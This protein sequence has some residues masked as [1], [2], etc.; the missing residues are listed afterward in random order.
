VTWNTT[1]LNT[2]NFWTVQVVIED[3]DANGNVKTKTPVDFLLKISTLVGNAPTCSITP[4]TDP[5][6]VAVGPVS[7]TVTGD[8]VDAGSTIEINVGGLPPGATMTP[9]LPTSGAPPISSV[10]NWVPGPGDAGTSH[11]VFFTVTDNNARQSQCSRRIIITSDWRL[12]VELSD[13][14]LTSNTDRVNLMWQTASEVDN[15][16]F[17]VYRSEENNADNFRLIASY[18]SDASLKGLGT[19]STGKRYTYVDNDGLKP[20]TVYRYRL[21]DVSTDGQRTDKAV[22]QIRVESNE[23]AAVI[24]IMRLHAV[25]PNPVTDEAAVSFTLRDDGP[26]TIE[27]FSNDGRQVVVPVNG[28]VYSAGTH[29]VTVSTERLPAGSYVVVLSTGIQVRTQRFVVVR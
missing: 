24:S 18:V 29:T 10:F 26:V 23:A 21:V 20:G 19:S 15:A 14:T 16:G 5:L 11:T 25:T 12:P 28:K 4:G 22:R 2:S 27:I 17:E 6:I 13:F 1:G 9:T 3:L 7:F 8:D